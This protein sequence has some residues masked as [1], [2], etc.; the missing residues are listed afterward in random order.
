MQLPL[1]PEL[2][3]LAVEIVVFILLIF[4]LAGLLVEHYYRLKRKWL[5]ERNRTN[6]GVVPNSSS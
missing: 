6:A 3:A 4:A 2:E 1:V 5:K